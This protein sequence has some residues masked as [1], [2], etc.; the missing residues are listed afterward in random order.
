MSLRPIHTIN[1]PPRV[2]VYDQGPNEAL[3]RADLAV[4]S[5]FSALQSLRLKTRTYNFLQFGLDLLRGELL[6]QRGFSQEHVTVVCQK[7]WTLRLRLGLEAHTDPP[8]RET[9]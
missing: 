9:R 2:C 3:S 5:V 7:L 8:G 4:F 1:K 6:A